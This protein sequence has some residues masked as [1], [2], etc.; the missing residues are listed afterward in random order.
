MSDGNAPGDPPGNL[1]INVREGEEVIFAGP[2][3]APPG[4]YT[5]DPPYVAPAD[6]TVYIELDTTKHTA[7]VVAFVAA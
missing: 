7:R 5:F 2:S 6:G 3:H 1:E 4:T